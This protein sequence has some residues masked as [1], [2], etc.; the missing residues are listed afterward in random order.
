[1]DDVILVTRLNGLVFALNPDLIERADC[2]PDT[3]VTLVDG[4]K[5]VITEPILELVEKVIFF[6]ARVLDAAH[7]LESDGPDLHAVP[8][9]S[10]TVLKICKQ[11]S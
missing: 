5:Y 1:M 8:D 10:S 2:T 9:E 4:T 7:T 11:E 3:V 6:R